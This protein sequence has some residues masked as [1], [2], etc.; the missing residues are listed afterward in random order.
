MELLFTHLKSIYKPPLSHSKTS[1]R[2]KIKETNKRRQNYI[3]RCMVC[4][5][6]TSY[7]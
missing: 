6:I 1:I 2:R 4:V 3:K 7:S 5:T